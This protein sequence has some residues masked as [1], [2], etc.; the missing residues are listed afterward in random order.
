MVSSV[1]AV[2]FMATQTLYAGYLMD[3]CLRCVFGHRW[4]N[5]PNTLPA[6]SGTTSRRLL[7]FFILCTSTVFLSVLRESWLILQGLSNSVSPPSY[8]VVASL[9]QRLITSLHVHSPFQDLQ[10]IRGQIN[11]CR[12]LL[13]RNNGLGRRQGGWTKL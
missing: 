13:V 9:V 8:S 10:G 7:A 5:I 1:V 6:S 11:R 4:V 2:L 3:V 12:P